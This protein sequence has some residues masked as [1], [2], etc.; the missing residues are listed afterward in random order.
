MLLLLDPRDFDTPGMP[1]SGSNV[2]QGIAYVDPARNI[3]AD[4]TPDVNDTVTTCRDLWDGKLP[5]SVSESAV[6]GKQMQSIVGEDKSLYDLLGDTVSYRIQIHFP[7]DSFGERLKVLRGE[8]S[9]IQRDMDSVYPRISQLAIAA[10][11]VRI[12]KDLIESSVLSGANSSPSPSLKKK[13]RKPL[14]PRELPDNLKTLQRL[15]QVFLDAYT[16]TSKDQKDC[17]A[18]IMQIGQ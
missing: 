17:R 1:G 13:S 2:N 9:R 11:L 5:V 6:A 16:V 7:Q 3:L 12:E 4:G 8:I 18:P 10:Q 14:L 15:D